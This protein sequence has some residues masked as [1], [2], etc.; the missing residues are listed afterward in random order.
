MKRTIEAKKAEKL[1]K[2]LHHNDFNDENSSRVQFV[3]SIDEIK[4]AK[5]E[6][7]FTNEELDVSLSKSGSTLP[8]GQTFKMAKEKEQE[9]IQQM[10]FA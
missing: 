7:N 6:T 3:S 10:K 4:Q 9:F 8:G 2:N 5:I 1:M